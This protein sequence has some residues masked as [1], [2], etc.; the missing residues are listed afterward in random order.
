[1]WGTS[2]VLGRGG[3][4]VPGPGRSE[5]R[6]AV[7][8]APPWLPRGPGGTLA[9]CPGA[10][11]VQTAAD[12]PLP[13]P[14]VPAGRL[15]HPGGR[16]LAGR[17][18]GELR[19]PVLLL[20]FPV[21]RQP[22]HRHRH[23]GHGHRLRGLHRGHQGE[24]V[25]PAH[26]E[27]GEGPAG[28][29][30][31]LPDTR[32]PPLGLPG[33]PGASSDRTGTRV[34][35]R[36]P[37]CTSPSCTAPVLS[38]HSR[39]PI[40]PAVPGLAAQDPLIGPQPGLSLGHELGSRPSGHLFRRGEGPLGQAP[41]NDNAWGPRTEDEAVVSPGW[42]PRS[43][44]R[45]RE[46]KSESPGE[47]GAHLHPSP[48]PGCTLSALL[49]PGGV[50]PRGRWVGPGHRLHSARPGIPGARPGR[51]LHGA[52]WGSRPGGVCAVGGGASAPGS[53]TPPWSR[54][55]WQWPPAALTHSRPSGVALPVRPPR[56]PRHRAHVSARGLRPAL[57]RSGAAH[58]AGRF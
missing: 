43:E 50:T 46:S 28:W 26:R 18:A 24:Q 39:D 4:Q 58:K 47:N 30:A 53:H 21:G 42:A 32:A 14:A 31:G 22:A 52:E 15:R 2:W 5:G 1:M 49:L 11:G 7:P 57:Q 10:Q 40:P 51:C 54:R 23:P 41:Y 3:G 16:H 8:W 6:A 12:L 48:G 20:P 56:G 37:G 45:L 35:T 27:C 44:L 17:H 9:C 34:C 25:P 36:V 29:G 38:P 55:C 33:Q 13:A 19:H